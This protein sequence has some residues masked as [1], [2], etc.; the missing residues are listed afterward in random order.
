VRTLESDVR[1]FHL[2]SEEDK[3]VYFNF[4]DLQ[5]KSPDSGERQCKSRA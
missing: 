3:I 5:R 2:P 1:G 4:L